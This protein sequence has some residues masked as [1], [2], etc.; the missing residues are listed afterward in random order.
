MI[1]FPR[2]LRVITLLTLGVAL[3]G[4]FP[5]WLDTP[6][7]VLVLD[8]SASMRRRHPR[9]V[10]ETLAAW[11]RFDGG[12]HPVVYARRHPGAAGDTPDP[13]E[14]LTNVGGALREAAAL[15]PRTVEK[16]VLLVTDAFWTA[17]TL[18]GV[19]A[20][21]RGQGVRVYALRPPGVERQTGVIDLTAPPR[22]F[23][24]EPFSVRGR[25]GASSPGPVPVVLRRDGVVVLE[26]TVD[27]GWS[28]IAEVEHLAEAEQVGSVAFSLE[29]RDRTATA[30]GVEVQVASSP[31]VLYITDDLQSSA[32][33]IEL[34]RRAG[35]DVRPALAAAFAEGEEELGSSDIVVLD[36]IPPTALGNSLERI[37][38]LVGTEG[39]G[40]LAIGGRKGL[41][42][43][44]TRDS[45]LE[46]LL[47]VT[48]GYSSP[49]PTPRASMVLVLDTSFSM[50]F[51]GK[52][53][54][55]IHGGKPRK[56][57]VALES[58]RQVV[59]IVRPGDKL[60]ILGNSTDLFWIRQLGEVPDPE[61]AGRELER[62]V[63]RGDGLNFYS[64][65][66]EAWRALRDDPA[67]VRHVMVFCD[68]EDIDQYEV[69]GE[70]HAHD[71]IRKMAEDG[72]TVS[73]LS[74]GQLGD[75]DVPFL[76]TAALVG[77]GDFYLIS[78][79]TALP[80]Y[81]VSE[82][83]KLAARY[84][85]EEDIDTVLNDYTP[86]LAGIEG[87]LPPLRGIDTVTPRKGSVSPVGTVVGVP[88][89]TTGR[90]GRGKTAVFASDSGSRWAPQ[91]LAWGSAR[92][93]WLRLLFAVA[94]EQGQSR[95][96][97]PA[98]DVEPEDR[99]I[100]LRYRG[101]KP[102]LP[103]WDDLWLR[104]GPASPGEEWRRLERVGLRTYRAAGA[105]FDPGTYR[106]VVATDRVPAGELDRGAVTI[107]TSAELLPLPEDWGPVA[108][109]LE[110]T[111]G[112]MLG[113][114]EELSEGGRVVAGEGRAQFALIALGVLLLCV[115]TFVNDRR[116][117]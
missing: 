86:L 5:G 107:A 30:V 76:R 61:Q 36:D 27:V 60:G 103:P 104:V 19:G 43:E 69:L 51:R 41:G 95:T 13:N 73:I 49:P 77:R 62:V 99:Q 67:P 3:L 83:R 84:F 98:L 85:L 18:R 87:A 35:I 79:L 117:R 32:K 33:L 2:L 54:R 111:G 92:T 37:R 90:Y 63:P 75:K 44:E 42:S 23:L 108:A 6:K 114:P 91:W 70:G 97:S 64:A 105:P 65:V 46:A 40:L 112:K 71:L 102:S 72:V 81:F 57:D 68:A 50:A 100:T 66:N 8:D 53:E 47:P 15:Y 55:S 9:A 29:V 24:S 16:R 109:L 26:R 7:N 28:G 115:E 113:A 38:D 96:F 17:D 20:E 45:E 31:K 39:R 11:R 93:F 58:T 101:D 21:L 48:I 22:V 110:E 106:T 34:W 14:Q 78:V 12:R 74:I 88:L 56:I 4:V 94:P 10:E 89:V 1:S 80:R 59:K 25:V 82:Y 116:W 52:G